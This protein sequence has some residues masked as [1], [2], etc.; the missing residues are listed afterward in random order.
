M[1]VFKET[2]TEVYCDNCGELLEAWK[3]VTGISREW[4][5]YFVRQEGATTGKRIKCKKCR[6]EARIEKCSLIKKYGSPGKDNDTCLGFGKEFDDEP[7]EKCKRCIACNSFDWEE[8]AY[9]LSI[10]GKRDKQMKGVVD[11]G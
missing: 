2:R 5:K 7:I 1:A 8:E 6:I 9:R 3:G 4:A 10:E 11:N